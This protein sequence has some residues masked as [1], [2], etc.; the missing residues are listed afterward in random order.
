MSV[1]GFT[2]RDNIEEK[3]NSES[4]TESGD[5]ADE[6]MKNLD[7][8][9]AKGEISEE[10]YN[11]AME[12]LEKKQRGE[13]KLE[14]GKKSEGIIEEVFYAQPHEKVKVKLDSLK[15]G[16]IEKPKLGSRYHI[17]DTIAQAIKALKS[18][19]TVKSVFVG[20]GF[21]P[22][23]ILVTGESL[24]LD[25]KEKQYKGLRER[26][27]HNIYATIK[28]KGTRNKI[29]EFINIFT[30]SF[31]Y[32]P[33]KM[34][35]WKEFTSQTEIPKDEAIKPWRKY[36]IKE[37]ESVNT[38]PKCGAEL[39]PDAE[40]CTQCGNKLE[41]TRDKKQKNRK[42]TPLMKKFEKETDKNAI[43]KGEVTKQFK[44]WKKKQK[45]DFCPECGAELEPD[46]EFCVQCGRKVQ[47]E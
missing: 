22:S 46:S 26:A 10:T 16:I 9:L 18:V 33:W 4:L 25:L 36:P 1:W 12:R 37:K 30:K 7:E 27:P 44:N 19:D 43:W 14:K 42:L 5:S 40:F 2:F 13:E 34:D 21:I 47:G 23:S 31:D 15:E 45:E 6:L 35:D 41:T 8:R 24:E 20:E 17:V 3:S 11:K 39:E 28:L 32:S 29:S 38:C